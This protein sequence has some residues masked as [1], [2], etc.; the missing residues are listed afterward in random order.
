MTQNFN[1]NDKATIDWFELDK[2]SGNTLTVKNT[3]YDA[4][5]K[6]WQMNFSEEACFTEIRCLFNLIEDIEFAGKC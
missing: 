5:N 6:F 1:E 2:I 4:V 3:F